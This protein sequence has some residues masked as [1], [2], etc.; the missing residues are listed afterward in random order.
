MK[1]TSKIKTTS[2]MKTT[3]KVKTTSKILSQAFQVGFWCC[4]KQIGSTH[5]V[6]W[7]DEIEI[8]GVPKKMRLGV[9]LISLQQRIRFLNCFFLLKLRSIQNFWIQNHFCAIF[10]GWDVCK[11]KWNSWLEDSVKNYSK[12]II[13]LRAPT[14]F[15]NDQDKKVITSI[16]SVWVTR[17]VSSA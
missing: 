11:T 9:C 5:Q 3:S 8:Q 16:Q 14:Y 15:E 7:E 1:M 17:P 6:D 13:Q 4:K 12:K 10:M 2:K